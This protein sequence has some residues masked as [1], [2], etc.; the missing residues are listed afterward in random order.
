MGDEN[1]ESSVSA[2]D[3]GIGGLR[4][5]RAVGTRFHPTNGFPPKLCAA[6][7]GHP[8]SGTSGV[9]QSER[10]MGPIYQSADRAGD[11]LGRLQLQ[12]QR[13]RPAAALQLLLQQ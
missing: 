7:T 5:D 6:P 10:A 12:G 2:L 3:D 1:E 4:G 9:Y 8:G 13:P 11:V